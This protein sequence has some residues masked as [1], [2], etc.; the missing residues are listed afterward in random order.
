MIDI[1]NLSFRYP[2]HGD[3]VF[4]EFNMQLETGHIY[5]LLGPN[6]AGKSTLLYL[7]AGLL[8]PQEGHVLCDG[9]DVRRRLP[10]TMREVF[11]VPDE[12]E[13]PHVS[14]DDYIR[15]NSVFYPHF[16]EDDMHTYLQTFGMTSNVNLGAL[17]LGQRKKIFMSFAM[18][19]HTKVLLMDEPTNG[20]DILGKQQFREF[21]LAGKKADSIFVVSTHQVKDVEQILDHVLMIDHSHVIAD[22]DADDIRVGEALDLEAFYKDLIRKES[23]Y[24]QE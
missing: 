18:A 6:G 21:I 9:I 2:S 10:A 23:I 4:R 11:I 15:T 16:S 3:I 7:M 12:F 13:L 1:Q 24:V 14:L 19:T 20:L 5:G 8:T 22:V 17:S